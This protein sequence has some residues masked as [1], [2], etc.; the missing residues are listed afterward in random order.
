MEAKR[1][2]VRVF[3][4]LL[5]FASAFALAPSS[6]FA[7]AAEIN[8]YGGYYWPGDLNGSFR[9]N[10]LLGVRGGGFVTKNFELGGNYAWS[11][12]FQ[13]NHE[14][15]AAS[16]AGDLGFPQGK[17]RY[18]LWEAEFTYNFSK[19]SMFGSFLRPYVTVGGGALRTTVKDPDT[20]VL[21]VRPTILN[22]G[23]TRFITNDVLDDAD[24]FFTFSY[25]GGL[26]W[27]RVYGPMGFFA[28]FR[29]R[30]VPNFLGNNSTWPELS[31]GLTFSWGER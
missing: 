18:N 12:H 31:G 27:H 10:Q 16:F 2:N 17:V 13:P 25:G 4:F 24:T 26:K 6:L 22:C 8:P 5:L 14:N 30:T 29:G 19:R 1:M 7:Q 9:G 15:E 20:F 28:D 21:N 23:C 11:N 3:V